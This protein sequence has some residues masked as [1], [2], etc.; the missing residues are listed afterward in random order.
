M[1][2]KKEQIK[3]G[4]N[5][6]LDD[7][8]ITVI[9][10]VSLSKIDEKKEVTEPVSDAVNTDLTP[11][12]VIAPTAEVAP[13]VSPVVNETPIPVAQEFT[14]PVAP[15]I[16]EPIVV[17]NPPVG[18]AFPSVEP[19]FGVE[20]PSVSPQGIPTDLFGTQNNIQTPVNLND[21][22]VPMAK[23]FNNSFNTGYG[24]SGGL[25]FL[26]KNDV[27]TYRKEQHDNVDALCNAILGVINDRDDKNRKIE[28]IKNNIFGSVFTDENKKNGM[29]NPL[30]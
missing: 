29:N 2:E 28:T 15:V 14:A 9:N 26:T 4:K 5:I 30:Y 20:T 16:P 11:D 8:K 10:E 13:I 7:G 24:Y 21:L 27:E 22:N 12:V 1:S 18:V 3:N 25:N 17:P 6:S 19:S 23:E